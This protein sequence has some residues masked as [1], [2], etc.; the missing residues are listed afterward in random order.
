VTTQATVNG[1][2]F[3]RVQAAGFVG[4]ASAATLC[5]S[6]KAR[7]GACLVMAA[8]RVA[9]PQPGRTTDTRLA[10]LR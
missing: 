10:R 5:R 3:W 9:P 4:Q 2:R 8:P 7:G 1:R 6:V